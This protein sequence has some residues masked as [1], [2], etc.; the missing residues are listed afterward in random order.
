MQDCREKNI[1]KKRRNQIVFEKTGHYKSFT[2]LLLNHY[3]F[4]AEIG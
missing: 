2:F 3:T 4:T 1:I